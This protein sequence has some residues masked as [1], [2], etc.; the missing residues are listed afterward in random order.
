MA[1]NKPVVSINVRPQIVAAITAALVA[2]GYLS[3]GSR[4]ASV[5]S[6]KRMNP[7]KMAG[8]RELMLGRD[9]NSL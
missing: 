3:K 9:L 4:I 2:A 5:R 1:L 6:L 7:W 8:L